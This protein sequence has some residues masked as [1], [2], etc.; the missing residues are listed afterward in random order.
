MKKTLA[1]IVLI[2]GVSCSNQK[3]FNP[4]DYFSVIFGTF[5][6]ECNGMCFQGYLIK[7]DRIYKIELPNDDFEQINID[8][9][10][11]KELIDR[12]ESAKI[13]DVARLLPCNIENY[14][15][16]IGNPD[17]QDQ[18][19]ISI[20]MVSKNKTKKIRID[21]DKQK[22]PASLH[23]FIDAVKNLKLL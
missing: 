23:N 11:K 8:T 13:R 2:V 1:L 19:G 10:K 7:S 6:G 18:C 16:I 14:N 15:E 17:K 22:C 5:C 3:L 20:L 9:I 21:N 4:A 12:S